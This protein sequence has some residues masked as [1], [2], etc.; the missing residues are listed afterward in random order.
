MSNLTITVDEKTLKLARMRAL[1]QDTSVNAV[2]REYL[3]CYAGVANQHRDAV[4]K[5]L[6]LSDAVDSGRGGRTWTREDLHERPV[7]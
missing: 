5:V 1:E 6:G 4:Q 7:Q 2:L 3:E